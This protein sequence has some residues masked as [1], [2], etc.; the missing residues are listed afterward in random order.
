M[1]EWLADPSYAH[2]KPQLVEAREKS[3]V[4]HCAAGSRSLLAAQTLQRLGFKNVSSMSGGFNDWSAK[5]LPV[6]K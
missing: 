2:H 6:E 5:G 3:V 1:I 4:I